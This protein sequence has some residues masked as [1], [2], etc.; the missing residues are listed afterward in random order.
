[1]E[2]RC[3]DLSAC[4]ASLLGAGE[5]VLCQSGHRIACDYALPFGIQY[6]CIHP[7]SLDIAHRSA[8]MPSPAQ[9]TE[10]TEDSE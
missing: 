8:R 2:K 1:M 9:P 3:P 7:E 10:P 6:F 4:Q 5:L